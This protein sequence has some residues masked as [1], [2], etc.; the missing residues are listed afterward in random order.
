MPI[1]N[2][3]G[4]EI[5][6]RVH[7]TGP[8]NLIFL[9]GW[10]GNGSIW[11]D[12][13]TKLDAARYRVICP[14]LRGHGCSGCP[15]HGYTWEG[16]VRDILAIADHE[17]ARQFVLV[18]FSVGGKLAC[19]LA[20]KHH[21]RVSAQVL[22]APVGPGIAPITREAGLHVCREAGDK[23]RN[24]EF[25]RNWFGRSA[26]DQVVDACCA[27]IAQTPRFVLE[28]TAEIALWTSL[29][30]DIGNLDLPTL[31]VTG[32]SDPVYHAAFQKEET[33]P[34]LNHA[35]TVTLDS[36]HFIPLECPVE[37]ASLI[38]EFIPESCAKSSEHFGAD[39]P[40]VAHDFD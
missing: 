7:G 20:A 33:L 32:Q 10:G 36:G 11:K 25:F 21:E 15:T 14:D 3:D 27:A 6:Y 19:Y 5:H 34:F 29:A 16:F 28:A 1:I 17:R 8:V 38:S 31:V 39:S 13:V 2:Q 4:I 35:K 22:I 23:E 24:K 12:I 37:L 26:T 18:G 30:S 40:P 9:H